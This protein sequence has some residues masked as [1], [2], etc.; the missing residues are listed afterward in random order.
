MATAFLTCVNS[1][2][3]DFVGQ[4]SAHSI[5]QRNPN[6]KWPKVPRHT[7]LH[8]APPPVSPGPSTATPGS[9]GTVWSNYRG[10][11][12]RGL[13]SLARAATGL[14]PPKIGPFALG[15][16]TALAP[17]PHQQ[18]P[19]CSICKKWRLLWECLPSGAYLWAGHSGGCAGLASSPR[20]LVQL[21]MATKCSRMLR[22]WHI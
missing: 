6:S 14:G 9:L 2:R 21:Y 12:A 7:R 4:Y 22:F 11:A 3:S 13:H 1:W 8:D 19:A 10:R 5:V 16:C 20:I 18:R 15:R 17:P